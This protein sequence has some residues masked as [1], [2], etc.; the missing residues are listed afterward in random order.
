V[1]L[2]T[3]LRILVLAPHTDDAELGAGGTLARWL[4]EGHEV[5]S[6]AFSIARESVPASFPSDVLSNEV[7][8]AASTL[9]INEH[10]LKVLDYPVRKFPQYRQEI[11]E[12]MVRLRSEIKPDV[13]LVPATTDVHQDHV[14]IAQE[15]IR[16]FKSVTVL[17]YELPWN[18]IL[19]RS[20]VLVALE[21]RHVE[22]KTRALACYKSQAH[23]DYMQKDFVSG[24][25]RYRGV[26][27]GLMF[28]EAF[29]SIRVVI[30]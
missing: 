25:A 30:R 17:G 10:R 22:A 5:H 18:N 7:R 4:H 16:A 8:A 12:D 2:S 28:A 20:Q 27:V 19:F 21:A 14:T 29:E 26:T 13:V 3:S 6:V 24:W 15:A 1:N 11:L 23:R 9:G